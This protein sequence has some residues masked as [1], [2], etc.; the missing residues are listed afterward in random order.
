M[1]SERFERIMRTALGSKSLEAKL[2]GVHGKSSGLV[3]VGT[4]MHTLSERTGAGRTGVDNRLVF[5]EIEIRTL[6]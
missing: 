4:F 5:N 6:Y 3:K 2:R 1:Q